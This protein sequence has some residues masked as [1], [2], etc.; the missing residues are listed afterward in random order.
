MSLYRQILEKLIPYNKRAIDQNLKRGDMFYLSS[1]AEGGPLTRKVIVLDVEGTVAEVDTWSFMDK[2]WADA[3]MLVD[4]TRVRYCG[5]AAP[6]PEPITDDQI[7]IPGL[8]ET[9]EHA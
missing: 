5:P 6:A 9:E 3:P 8:A 7:Q 4:L 2:K 1:R